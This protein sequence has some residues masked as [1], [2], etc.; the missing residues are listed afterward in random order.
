MYD[1]DSSGVVDQRQQQRR[2]L[3]QL[4]DA[5]SRDDVTVVRQLTTPTSGSG[6]LDYDVDGSLRGATPLRAA[7][8][9]GS[10]ELCR[11]LL[12][13]GADPDRVDPVSGDTAL[14]AA[15]AAGHVDVLRALLD[16]RANS[17]VTNSNGATA[18]GAAAQVVS[19]DKPGELLVMRWLQL[20]FDFDSTAVRLRSLRSQ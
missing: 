11:C 5:I 17:E 19:T 7:A 2:S 12:A 16:A 9:R 10:A 8:Q 14:H 15:A 4:H 20:P 18:L 1:T 6:R 13:A 3:R